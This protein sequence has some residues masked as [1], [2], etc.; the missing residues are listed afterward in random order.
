MADESNDETFDLVIE[1]IDPEQ[2]IAVV[3]GL[4][5]MQMQALSLG[6]IERA[7]LAG[8]TMRLFFM[9]NPELAREALLHGD[10]AEHVRAAQMPDDV[11]NELVIEFVDGRIRDAEA[12]E[13]E[14]E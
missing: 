14:I 4:G 12:A 9:E 7:N 2:F 5:T 13:V 3:G 10:G 6:A 11:L 8:G 1:D